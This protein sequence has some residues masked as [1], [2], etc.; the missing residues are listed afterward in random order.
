MSLL[1]RADIRSF[2]Q[3][4]EL[5]E[6]GKQLA[7]RYAAAKPFPHVVLDD[8]MP[9]AALAQVLSA[10]QAPAEHWETRDNARSLKRANGDDTHMAADVQALIYK[11]HSSAFLE[12]LEQLTG[13]QGL[14]PDPHLD[15]GGLHAIEPG[16]YLKIHADFNKSKRLKLDRR[17][18]LLLYLNRDWQ[19][20]WGGQLELW[21]RDMKQCVQRVTPIFNRCVVFST[22]ETSYHGHPEPL[23]CPAGRRRSSIALYYYTQGRPE[24]ERHDEHS[25]LYQQRPGEALFGLRGQLMR[26]VNRLWTR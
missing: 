9:A 16:G 25:T 18:N 26:R 15:G 24:H 20:D 2:F 7:Q 5:V 13:I 8:F 6:K 1:E 22:T 17:V 21:D 12:F 19:D 10:V 3:R 23:R 4:S 14:L 11:L